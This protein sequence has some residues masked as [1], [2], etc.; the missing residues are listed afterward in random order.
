MPEASAVDKL[1]E[2]HSYRLPV[3]TIVFLVYTSDL[4]TKKWEMHAS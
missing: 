3:T 4:A 2:L 1:V